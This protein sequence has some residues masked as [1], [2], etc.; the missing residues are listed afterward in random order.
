MLPDQ[1]T[2]DGAIIK[3]LIN[4]VHDLESRCNRLETSVENLQT[5]CSNYER[6]LERFRH[7]IVRVEEFQG[8]LDTNYGGEDFDMNVE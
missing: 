7:E 8:I 3:G 4:N 6:L 1:E 2:N 5:R